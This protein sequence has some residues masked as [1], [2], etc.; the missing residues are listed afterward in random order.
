[1]KRVITVLVLICIYFQSFAQVN[2][3][4]TGSLL[5]K[6]SGNG[7]KEPSYLFGTYHLLLGSYIDSIPGLRDAMV[8]TTQVVGEIDML[9]QSSLQAK[10]MQAGILPPEE[11]YKNL[12]SEEEYTRLDNHLKVLMGAG[13][14]QLGSFKPGMISPM[15][16]LAIYNRVEP[17]FNPATFVGIDSHIQMI[18]KEEDKPIIPLETIEEQIYVLFDAKP[19]KW[20]MESLLCTVGHIDEAVEDMRVMID[21]YMAADLQ[22]MYTDSFESDDPCSFFNIDY[23]DELLVDRNNKWLEKIP[24]IIRENSSLIAVGAL[25][26][27]GEE[28]LLNRLNEMGYTIESVK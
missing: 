15:L 21:D 8:S 14:D 25:H 2:E 26:L 4:F 3:P 13:L 1:M 23:K 27:G 11:S 18:A 24:Q 16:M 7:L 9:D 20:Q 17:D 6:I 19:Q 10:M 12:L 5:W 22:K 28:G